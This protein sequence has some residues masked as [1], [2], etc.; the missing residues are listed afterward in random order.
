MCHNERRRNTR[1][2]DGT[3]SSGL[4]AD[5]SSCSW[6]VASFSWV[7]WRTRPRRPRRPRAINHRRA[8]TAKPDEGIPITDATVLKA[9][10]TCHRPDDKSQMSRISFQRNTPEGWQNTIQRMAALNGLQH[11]S[12]DRARRREVPLEQSRPGARRGQAGGVGSGAAVDRLQVH[13]QRRRREHLQQVS[14]AGPRD[15]AAPHA[16]GVGPA[17]RDAS[18]LVSAR[19]QPGVPAR[20]SGAARAARPTAARPT[21]ATRSR[22]RSIIS[23]STFPLKTPEWTAWSATMRPARLDGT[24]TLSGWELGKGAIYGTRH[25][26]R[27]SRH[28]R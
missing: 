18:R 19:R 24:W 16:R 21:R 25:G 10:G 13:R 20:R 5:S 17:R 6:S 3:E 27:R 15:F 1:A 26:H 7:H 2:T 4:H 14:F 22:R 9:C 12:G 11:R 8:P 23:P 28:A